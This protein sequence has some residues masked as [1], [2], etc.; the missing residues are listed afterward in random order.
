MRVSE[1]AKK[2]GVSPWTVRYYCNNGMLETNRTPGG[3]RTITEE[4]LKRFQQTHGLYPTSTQQK[5]A[6][7]ARS[8]SG[9]K[10]LIQA[11]LD[12]LEQTYGTP[13][14]IYTDTGSGLNENR[15]GLWKLI[16]D[17]EEGKIDHIYITYQ[18]RLTRFGYS[19]LEHIIQHA[20]CEL[21]V[22][23]DK[24]KYSLEKELMDDFMSLIASFAGRFYRM[25]GKQQQKQLLDDAN[26][27]IDNGE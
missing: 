16:H 18:D 2:L 3:H 8:S 7:Y 4:Q 26:Q 24:K 17:A 14:H 1:V 20:G 11:Q 9:D 5:T 27:R 10:K 12:E 6:H 22:L 25:R 15:K 19:Y 13:D 21:T 23:H